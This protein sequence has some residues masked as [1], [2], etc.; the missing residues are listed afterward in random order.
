MTLQKLVVHCVF[1]LNGCC[2]SQSSTL[3]KESAS[4]WRNLQS[5]MEPAI[6]ITLFQRAS[7][8]PH[9]W[10]P[11]WINAEVC[12]YAL[13]GSDVIYD[14]FRCWTYTGRNTGPHDCNSHN[15]I[16]VIKPEIGHDLH[17]QNCYVFTVRGHIL[18]SFEIMWHLNLKPSSEI[19]TASTCQHLRK[20]R[21]LQNLW[22]QPPTHSSLTVN[23]KCVI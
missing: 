11:V 5:R 12:Q 14:T 22:V 18:I 7:W 15:M 9:H 2:Q 21:R 3:A 16:G 4:E 8:I 20:S 13:C 10:L 23:M 19:K 17:S 1:V 6:V